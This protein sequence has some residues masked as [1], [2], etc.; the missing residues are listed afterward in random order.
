MEHPDDPVVWNL[1]DRAMAL[2]AAERLAF[3]DAACADD[4]KRRA[5]VEALLSAADGAGGVCST[6]DLTTQESPHSPSVATSPDL[7]ICPY[8]LLEKIGEGGIGEVWMAEQRRPIARRVAIKIIKPGMDSSEVIARFE[9][10][11]NRRL[12][13]FD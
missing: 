6:S 9:A 5:Q 1:L 12:R 13:G 2:P 4:P 11:W 10:D 8:K 3:L 7:P